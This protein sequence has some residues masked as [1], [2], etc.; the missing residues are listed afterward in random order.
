MVY[1]FDPKEIIGIEGLEDYA[2][3]YSPLQPFA[4][5]EKA[6][7][8]VTKVA[9]TPMGFQ[10]FVALDATG[11]VVEASAGGAIF[12]YVDKD[13]VSISYVRD[14]EGNLLRVKIDGDKVRLATPDE[15]K[16]GDFQY[17]IKGMAAYKAGMPFPVCVHGVIKV[18]YDFESEI[19]PVAGND[20]AL[21]DSKRV[22]VADTTAGDVI[23][24]K[25]LAVDDEG[26]T[27]ILG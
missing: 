14:R 15:I 17:V 18:P 2:I 26:V 7:Y 6:F 24:G 8:V 22:K 3:A 4:G 21:L 23:I 20:L 1:V 10:T 9:E 12:G 5:V 19:K 27:F 25:A 13:P 11:N 16:S